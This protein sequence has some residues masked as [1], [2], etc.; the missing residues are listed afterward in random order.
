MTDWNAIATDR[1]AWTELG[2]YAASAGMTNRLSMAAEAQYRDQPRHE[3]EVRAAKAREWK[4]RT[5]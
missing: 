5:S 4:D 1:S 2:V 3:P